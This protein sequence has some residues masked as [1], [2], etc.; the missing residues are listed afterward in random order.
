MLPREVDG[1]V[2]TEDEGWKK[3]QSRK[4]NKTKVGF[5]RFNDSLLTS[6]FVC[7]LPRDA[8]KMELREVCKKIGVLEDIYLAGRRNA[9]G[10]FFSF[11]KFANVN[12]P[13][14]FEA[15]LNQVQ[16]RWRKLKANIA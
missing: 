5:G 7:N 3:V 9:A 2:A 8:N 12:K 1:R 11:L 4:N 14:T 10:S 6:F 13:E 16:L 15:A